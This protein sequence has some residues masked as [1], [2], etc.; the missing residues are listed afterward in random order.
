[1]AVAAD[2]GAKMKCEFCEGVGTYHN[3]PLYGIEYLVLCEKC[4]GTGIKDAAKHLKEMRKW[5]DNHKP[6]RNWPEN[7]AEADAFGRKK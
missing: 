1:M 5:F 2:L 4:N 3:P 6:P 7:P